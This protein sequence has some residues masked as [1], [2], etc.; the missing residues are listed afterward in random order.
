MKL[1]ENWKAVLQKSWSLWLAVLSAA[2][3]AIE[4]TLPLFTTVVP[5]NLFASLSM[6]TAIAA[7]MARVIHQASMH[8]VQEP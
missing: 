8:Q 7:A 4:V 3:S 5:P 6:I 2:L 1:I